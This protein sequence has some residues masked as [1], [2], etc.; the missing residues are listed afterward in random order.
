MTV[1]GLKDRYGYPLSTSSVAAAEQY[2][3]AIERVLA[4]SAG[5]E[6]ALGE[7][8]A[9]DDGFAL[10]HIAQAR[11]HQYRGRVAEAR[12]AAA[13]ARELGAGTSRREQQHV[14]AIATSIDGDNPR[15]AER[16]RDHLQEY[17]R[18]AYLLSQMTGPFSLIGF[19]GGP[20]WRRECFALLAPLAPA[21]GE[22]WW[23]LS[24]FAFL[25]NELEQF[26]AARDLAERSLKAYPRSAHTAHTVAH[27][28]FETGDSGGGS[29]FLEGWMPGY[30]REGQMFGHLTW[31]H[32]LFELA[33]GRYQHVLALYDSSLRPSVATG[34]AIITMA[35]A[36]AMLWR[37]DLYGYTPGAERWQEVRDFGAAAFARPGV[38]FA[39]LHC[40]FAYAATADEPGMGKLID[41]LHARVA[42][43]RLPAGDVVPA[44][45]EG[46]AA[47]AHG[48]FASMI[49]LVEPYIDQIVR[50][51]GSNAQR[52]VFE[53]TLLEAYLR[54]EAYDKAEALLRARLARRHSP[55]DA[56]HLGRAVAAQGDTA[57]ARTSLTR[58]REGW[59]T[60]DPGNPEIAAVDAALAALEG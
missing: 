21:Y 23:F 56:Y 60:A 4:G 35:D 33:A 51:G 41:G 18:D 9:A 40:A 13:R 26:G 58:A 45:A 1:T 10:A 19:G 37:C 48:D 36:A 27:I 34:A 8:L 46:I 11:M 22:D 17:P 7:A 6:E 28:A 20:D 15:A 14:A 39:D 53:D 2:N 57:G 32:A 12:A 24:A 54:A 29:A 25:H 43:G 3:L 59:R 38:T 47:F 42:E 49:R 30:P 50:V 44:L 16:I 5:Q 31:H 55:R 52:Q